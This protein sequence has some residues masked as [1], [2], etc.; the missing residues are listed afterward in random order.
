M[1][2]K[3][4]LLS[5]V[6]VLILGLPVFVAQMH[7][8]SSSS[9]VLT[10]M[11]ADGTI[12]GPCLPSMA[13]CLVQITQDPM[14]MTQPSI[15]IINN[16]KIVA[17]NIHAFS[18]DSN[19][20]NYVVQ[21][22]G[23]P[24]SLFPGASCII[25]FYTNTAVA[26]LTSNVVAKGTNTNATY[27]NLQAFQ[28]GLPGAPTNVTT[29]AG[30]GAATVTWSAPANNSG[31]PITGY[32]VSSSPGNLTCTTTGATTCTVLG[33]TVG[34]SY[35]F[36]VTATNAIGTG[37]VSSPSNAVIPFYPTETLLYSSLNPS[38]TGAA[39]TLSAQV[40]SV[41]GT[42]TTGTVSFTANGVAI[43]GCSAVALVSGTATCL[44]TTLPASTTPDAIIA[45]YSGAN[46]FP[47]SSSSTFNQY[48]AASL[49][50]TTVPG[51][52]TNVTVTPGNNQVSL[53]WLP[54]SN[55]GGSAITGY[56]VTYGVTTA[57]PTSSS[58][59]T[60]GCTT[61][62][63]L[64]CVVGGLTNGTSYTFMI[65]ATNSNGTGFAAFSS[66]ISPAPLSISPA[67]MALAVNGR[68]RI[69]ILT[70]NSAS[71]VIITQTPTTADFSP[72]LP[73]GTTLAPLTCITNTVLAANG[74]FCALILTPGA[75]ASSNNA[76]ALCT[77][78][79]APVPSVLAVNTDT[80]FVTVDAF[81]LGN[82]CI[83]QAGN[84]FALNDTTPITSSV[85]GT[86]VY[87]SDQ[88]TSIGWGGVATFD[89]IWGVDDTSSIVTPSPNAS[90]AD[91][92][93][94]TVGQ[95]NCDA[96]NDGVC[97]TNN[98]FA[99]YGPNG[100]V[101]SFCKSGIAGYL[102]WYVPAICELGPF[103]ST[104]LN[105]GN[106]P[107]LPGSQSC[108]SSDNIQDNLMGI[109]N[110]SSTISMSGSGYFS[111]MENSSDPLHNIWGQDFSTVGGDKQA[112]AVGDKFDPANILRCTRRLTI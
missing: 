75:T 70:N 107:S 90:S 41:N 96:I 112:G 23:C 110:F 10:V 66:S 55:T 45:T 54:P 111:S 76:S 29:T 88:A 48:V 22:N 92:A 36:T 33:L 69:I 74:G 109:A 60:S 94:Y 43:I 99:F 51:V 31:S 81:V 16:S 101:A 40:I 95:L 46:G 37:P 38:I 28:C 35:T 25:S 9:A 104:G 1:E 103:G 18:A 98:I 17:K 30:Y 20:I 85:G 53:S 93:I 11:R 24:S 3:K 44:T 5:W 42:P 13:N 87:P 21:N 6:F 58:Y 47:A 84:L 12:L 91:P 108:L 82:G 26:F 65:T 86:V 105:T 62:G 56:T 72:S 102:D 50:Q 64:S 34:T 68:S 97:A 73:T 59:T 67:I 78:G 7:A 89:S 77:T 71:P 15:S 39:V 2:V 63:T 61:A 19:F 32:T 14:C 27:F 8:K 106:Y 83:Y 4:K 49:I 79:V 52:P 57:S 100:D 80:G